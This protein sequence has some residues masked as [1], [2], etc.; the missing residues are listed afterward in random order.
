MNFHEWASTE[1]LSHYRPAPHDL[2]SLIFDQLS[3]VLL[4]RFEESIIIESLRP[5]L[6][7]DVEKAREIIKNAVSRIPESENL[8]KIFELI[9]P[10]KVGTRPASGES[11][12]ADFQWIKANWDTYRGLW[13]ALYSGRCLAAGSDLH[14]VR[15]AA[16]KKV[17]LENVLI[18]YFPK[19]KGREAVP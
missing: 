10:S 15:N 7:T 18:T 6:V 5:L 8:Q 12:K 2:H 3:K 19:E 9:S 13:V 1:R 14:A 4:R 17:K 16:E 11:R